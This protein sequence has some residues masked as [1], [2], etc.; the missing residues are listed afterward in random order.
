MNK[1]SWLKK[2]RQ[3]IRLFRKR[4]QRK[5]Q[6]DQGTVKC[7]FFLIKWLAKISCYAL[8][9]LFFL[10][11]AAIVFL[12]PLIHFGI[13]VAGSRLTGCQI[14]ADKVEIS[15]SQG[16]LKIINLQVANPDGF[17][18]GNMLTA[19]SLYCSIVPQTVFADTIIIREL[20]VRNLRIYP[21]IS[22]EK[23]LNFQSFADSFSTLFS[24]SAPEK[25]SSCPDFV[26]ENLEL[27]NSALITTD[28]RRNKNINGFSIRFNSLAGN[29]KSGMAALHG[30]QIIPSGQNRASM[31]EINSALLKF[32]SIPGK[33]VFSS[34][35]NCEINSIKIRFSTGGQELNALRNIVDTFGTCLPPA[36]DK[37]HHQELPEVHDF[38]IR[39]ISVSLQDEANSAGVTA[40]CKIF[41]G[42][43]TNGKT[44]LKN[45]S[46]STIRSTGSDLLNLKHVNVEFVP[47][48]IFSPKV[49]IRKFHA[50]N[51]SATANLYDRQYSDIHIAVDAINAVDVPDNALNSS[52]TTE[53]QVESF[54]LKNGVLR[55]RDLRSGELRGSDF[56]VRFS[57]IYGSW[58]RGS[59]GVKKLEISD[60][61]LQ[62][63]KLLKLE[64]ALF[65]F[66]PES[67]TSPVTVIRKVDFN[68]I[69]AVAVLN[70]NNRT[71]VYKFAEALQALISPFASDDL[72]RGS[73]A[74]KAD[75]VIVDNYTMNNGRF[76]LLD[77]RKNSNVS[78]LNCSVGKVVFSRARGWFGLSDLKICNPRNYSRSAHLLTLDSIQAAFPAGAVVQSLDS[79][80][81][82]GMHVKLEFGENG[83]SNIHESADAVC[84]LIAKDKF[85]CSP[86]PATPAPA[87]PETG[88]DSPII[89]KQF[90]LTDSSFAI[91][92]ARQ[93]IPVKVP[94]AQSQKNMV[95]ESSSN[96]DP[97]NTIHSIAALLEKECDGI[98][99]PAKL[100]IEQLDKTTG[101]GIKLLKNCGKASGDLLRG[102]FPRF[103]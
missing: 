25:N 39:D 99:N 7:R 103:K 52:E 2:I 46:V 85:V 47:E 19:D 79:L 30:L 62:N 80:E 21:E 28:L 82:K 70:E 68:G 11:V 33:S 6:N 97:V 41:H 44:V 40:K 16:Y 29:S 20:E 61:A 23:K 77:R 86:E 95:I 27:K 91:F 93:K 51:L 34:I 96:S 78:G 89:I 10:L 54:E 18:S 12:D 71:N 38:T 66:V 22:A 24:S 100:F 81:V 26:I 48:S 87:V 15:I 64:S 84:T 57:D 92:D 32:Q 76:F 60:P 90:S 65:D 4:H 98:T 55:V 14:S 56:D 37:E 45:V 5:H 102:L 35:R 50:E 94:L 73:S 9:L 1:K 101:P 17:S 63:I 74:E 3:K 72:A 36:M 59:L 43:L 83:K 13:T 53:L 42:S 88:N 58:N 67:L 69:S 31:L 75:S 8:V 49:Q